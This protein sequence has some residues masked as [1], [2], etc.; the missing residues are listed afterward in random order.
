MILHM[1]ADGDHPLVLGDNLPSLANLMT[2]GGASYCNNLSIRAAG[3]ESSS[4]IALLAGRMNS[5]DVAWSRNSTNLSKYPLMFKS[6][7]GL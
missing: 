4:K 6:P 2:D 3:S 7:T 1:M 5:S